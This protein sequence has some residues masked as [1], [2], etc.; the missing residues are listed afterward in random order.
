MRLTVGPLPASV[1]WRRRAIVLGAVLLPVLLIAYAC[2][3]FDST[4]ASKE[5]TDPSASRSPVSYPTEEP[6]AQP[7]ED[8]GSV[9]AGD[10]TG[11]PAGGDSGG[12]PG[13]GLPAGEVPQCADSDLSIAPKPVRT[14]TP[15]GARLQ[16]RLVITNI[17]DRPCSRDVGADQQEIRVM[18]GKQRIWS[19]DDCDPQHGQ[20]IEVLPS[21]QPI[22]RF[23]VAWDGRTSAPECRGERKVAPAGT[24][25]V[26][27][28]LGDLMS[29]PVTIEVVDPA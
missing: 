22:E 24:Y 3:A 7:S 23:W 4:P 14:R 5:R 20:H 9:G 11:P 17:S 6:S 25:T 28:R 19:S 2:G 13:G 16:I 18:Q 27:A 1:Y 8:D 29:E 26:F 15:K 12:A 21:Q 10:A